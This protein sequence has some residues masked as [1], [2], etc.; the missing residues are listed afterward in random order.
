MK[1]LLIII[2]SL[3]LIV[4]LTSCNNYLTIFYGTYTFDKVSYL[5]PVSSA[6]VDYLEEKMAGTRYRIEEDVFE[7]VFAP[8]SE[9]ASSSIIWISWTSNI[10][11]INIYSNEIY[12]IS[13]K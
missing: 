5:S 2:V 1:K 3:L 12:P 4:G 13:F 9:V 11:V 8:V 6:T 7:I 10:D